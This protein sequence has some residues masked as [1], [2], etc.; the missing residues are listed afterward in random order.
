MKIFKATVVNTRQLTPGMLRITLGGDGMAA[1]TSTGVGDE[2]LRVFLPSPGQS[3]PVLPVPAGDTWEYLPG[4][5]PSPMRTYTVRGVDPLLGTADIDFVVHD[6]GVA[7]AWA[8]QAKPG[9]VVGLNSPT[10][11]YHPPTGIEW[12][13]LVADATGLPAVARLVEL[14]PAGVR[15]RVLIEVADSSHCQDLQ[16]GPDVEIAWVY[17]GNGHTQSRLDELIRTIDLPA[18][19]GY[20]WF[21]GETKVLRS[22]RRHLRHERKLAP[23]S[24]KLIGYWTDKSEQWEERWEN[25][26]AATRR[27]LDELWQDTDRDPEDLEDLYTAK[28]ESLG[29]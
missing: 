20:V 13:V 2:Y 17:G 4:D 27:W 11:L 19:T 10:G 16:A 1:F 24:Y 9:D 3:E 26:D 14:A 6:G 28:L 8:L 15:T 22:V 5:T 21:A 12:Q 25:L 18:G 29:L 23:Q 7:A